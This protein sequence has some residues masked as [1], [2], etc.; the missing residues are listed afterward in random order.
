VVFHLIFFT[1]QLAGE[2]SYVVFIRCLAGVPLVPDGKGIG[3]TGHGYKTG[4]KSDCGTRLEHVGDGAVVVFV[5]QVV[6]T[7]QLFLN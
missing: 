2:Q 3:G 4:I 6:N 1:S 7:E 5:G